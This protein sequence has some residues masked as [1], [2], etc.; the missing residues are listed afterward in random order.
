MRVQIRTRELELSAEARRKIESSV[1]LTIGPL[2]AKVPVASVAFRKVEVLGAEP[3]V[4]CRV[5]LRQDDGGV[6]TVE[7]T[8]TDVE[9]AMRIAAW[10]LQH[11]LRRE[12]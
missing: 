5:R 10:R 6:L 3:A 9:A 1:R 2:S 8:A 7:D 12:G 11:R 4:H